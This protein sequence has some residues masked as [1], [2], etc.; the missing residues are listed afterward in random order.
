[1]NKIIINFSGEAKLG[2]GNVFLF[3]PPP[4]PPPPLE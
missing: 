1:M 3:Q 4:P 2:G